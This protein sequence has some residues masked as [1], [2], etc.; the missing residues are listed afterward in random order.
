MLFSEKP[1]LSE[2]WN[3]PIEGEKHP[4]EKKN[5]KKIFADWQG[6]STF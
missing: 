5:Q 2:D 6:K 1:N 3:V 4:A